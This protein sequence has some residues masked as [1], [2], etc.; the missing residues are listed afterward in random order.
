MKTPSPVGWI[1][2]CCCWAPM[3]KHISR[4]FVSPSTV[5]SVVTGAVMGMEAPG[6][7]E[8]MNGWYRDFCEC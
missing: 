1:G 8:G 2:A 5:Y 6:G 7:M 4:V 3:K